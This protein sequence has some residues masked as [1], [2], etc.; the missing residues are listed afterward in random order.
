MCSLGIDVNGV[1]EIV[2]AACKSAP[3]SAYEREDSSGMPM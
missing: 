1:G 3:G 2:L